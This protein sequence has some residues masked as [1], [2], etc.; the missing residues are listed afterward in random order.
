MFENKKVVQ[1]ICF[2][3]CNV[4]IARWL[5]LRNNYVLFGALFLSFVLK[6]FFTFISLSLV[7]IKRKENKKVAVVVWF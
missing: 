1:F 2:L 5:F 6:I 7:F 3:F 4:K